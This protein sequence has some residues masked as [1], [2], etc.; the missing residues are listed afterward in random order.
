MEEKLN[1]FHKF[2]VMNSSLELIVSTAVKIRE[3]EP[4]NEHIQD[5]LSIIINNAKFLQKS[6]QGVM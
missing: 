5:L 6:S 2:K 3:L 1:L 4:G